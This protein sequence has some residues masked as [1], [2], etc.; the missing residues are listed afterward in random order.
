MAEDNTFDNWVSLFSHRGSY[1]PLRAGSIDGTDS[2]AHDRAVIRAMTSRY[3][4]NTLVATDPNR[5]LFIGRL[6]PKTTE[7]KDA[8][9]MMIDSSE[10]IVEHEYERKL[11]GWI[12]R[13]LGGGIGGKK[14]SGQLRF[15]GRDRPFR[16]PM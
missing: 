11:K 10:I 1:D 16:R 4:P 2:L 14:E 15:G 3:K 12:P 6:N 5:T 9:K 13:R 8:N 7:G